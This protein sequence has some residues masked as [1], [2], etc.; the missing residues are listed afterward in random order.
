MHNVN[1]Y[2]DHSYSLEA[3]ANEKYRKWKVQ[4]CPHVS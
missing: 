2:H 1:F 3:V 4:V